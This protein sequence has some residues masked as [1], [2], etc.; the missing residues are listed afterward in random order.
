[1]LRTVTVLPVPFL[2]YLTLS[3]QTVGVVASAEMGLCLP[4]THLDR[5]HVL[6]LCPTPAPL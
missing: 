6:L 1:M 3:S 4:W 5:N 2:G